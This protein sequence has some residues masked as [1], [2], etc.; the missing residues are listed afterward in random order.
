MNEA[1]VDQRGRVLIPGEIRDST[2]LASGT[3]VAVEKERDVIVI[4]PLSKVKRGWRELCGI[5]PKRTGKPKWPTPEEIKD[6]WR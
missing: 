1:I 4:R 2:G 5:V 3:V 6:I